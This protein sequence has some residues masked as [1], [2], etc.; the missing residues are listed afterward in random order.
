MRKR[1]VIEKSMEKIKD[2]KGRKNFKE[3]YKRVKIEVLRLKTRSV[4]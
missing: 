2:K 4:N 3:E 1:E